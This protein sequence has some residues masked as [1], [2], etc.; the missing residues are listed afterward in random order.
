MKELEYEIFYI[1]DTTFEIH[2]CK[3][4]DGKTFVATT[5]DFKIAEKI[6]ELLSKES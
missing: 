3:N 6:V 2:R 1:D 5:E 4:I